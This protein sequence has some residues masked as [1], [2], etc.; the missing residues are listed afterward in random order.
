[1]PRLSAYRPTKTNDYRYF[2]RII[3]QQ[4]QVGGLDVLVHKYLGPQ[5][6]N[7]GTPDVTMPVY[8]KENPLFIEDLLLLENRDR[9][10]ESNV[11][12]MRMAYLE[13]DIDFDLTQFGLFLNND[14]LFLTVHYGNM[15]DIFGRKLMTGDCLEFPNLRDYNP[16]DTSISKSLPRYYVIQDASWGAEGF[17]QTWLPHLWRIKAT[18]LVNA[19]EYKSILDKPFEPDNIWDP[20]NFYPEGTIVN[21]CGKFY[22]AKQNVPPNEDINNLAYWEWIED[23]TTIADVISTYN[24]DLAINEAILAQ[25]HIEVPLSGFDATKFY[26]IPTYDDNQPAPPWS[27]EIG[28]EQLTPNTT[29]PYSGYLTG[30]GTAPNGLPVTP[31]VS[32]PLGPTKGQYCLRMDYYPNRLFRYDGNIWTMIQENV[33]TDLYQIPGLDNTQRSSFVN[34]TYTVET[35]TQGAIPSRQSLNHAL[36]PNIINGNDGGDKV[37]NPRPITQ[38]GQVTTF[39]VPKKPNVDPQPDDGPN[40]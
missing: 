6:G 35:N 32:F 24:K 23:P 28:M 30:D 9:N 2:D 33:R 16:L 12:V 7:E 11:Y 37:P 40:G 13:R 22:K 26:I 5:V 1:M 3:S 29:K 25:A 14:T 31:G 4:Y 18:P 10:Y 39:W 27:G 19:Q 34:N 15:M 38:P 36:Q 21:N 8:D 17:S 20:G